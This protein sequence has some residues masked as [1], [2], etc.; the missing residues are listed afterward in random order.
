MKLT[1][2]QKDVIRNLIGVKKNVQTLGGYA[3][4]GKTTIIRHIVEVLD[5]WAVCAYTG[6]ASNVLRKK[7][8]EEASTIHSLIYTPVEEDGEVRF[9]LKKDLGIGGFIVDEASMVSR[10]I[11]YD[12]LHFDLPIIFVGDHGQ[13]EPVGQ[14]VHLMNK[15]DYTLEEIHRNAGEIAFFAEWVRKGNRP[16][17]FRLHPEYR[18][19]VEFLSNDQAARRLCEADQ[20]ICAFNKTRVGLNRQVREQLGYSGDCP[21][22]GENVMCLRNNRNLGLFNGMQGEVVYN[23]VF[24][25]GTPEMGF[26]SDGTEYHVRYDP[27]QFNREKYDFSTNKEDPDPFDYAYC[28]TCHKAQ[29]DEW[30]TVMVFEQHCKGWDHKRWAYTAASRAKKRVLWVE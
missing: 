19:A 25:Y 20:I 10:E 22:P 4:T 23:H 11:H 17:D 7:G 5:T 18:G 29:G 15:P 24:E 6:K 21:E 9:M 16:S 3:G 13:L 26:E 2:Q 28:I 14:D 30:D 12:L 27:T 1:K 8:I